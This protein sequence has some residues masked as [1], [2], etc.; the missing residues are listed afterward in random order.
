VECGFGDARESE[1]G[2][3]F[4][5]SEDVNE[6]EGESEGDVREN[7]GNARESEGDVRER[8]SECGDGGESGDGDESESECESGD[9]SG[10]QQQELE[11]SA[12]TS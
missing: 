9:E 11:C 5:G 10:G 6:S 2:F 3:C 7:E 12:E 8:E 4:S 1:S